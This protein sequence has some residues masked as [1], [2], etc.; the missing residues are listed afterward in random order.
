[1]LVYDQDLGYDSD[2]STLLMLRMNNLIGKTSPYRIPGCDR[3][4]TQKNFKNLLYTDPEF[5]NAFN[6]FCYDW[7]L[8][9]WYDTYERAKIEAERM[10]ASQSTYDHIID[11]FN[12]FN[13]SNAT[14][15]PESVYDS[16]TAEEPSANTLESL[17][18]SAQDIGTAM[19]DASV[20][21]SN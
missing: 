3:K 19:A 2:L 14:S 18:E 13:N 11:R 16:P 6:N 1:M 7:V 10:S 5:F 9:Q 15:L 17:V 20:Y 21:D 4:F 12:Q 8:R